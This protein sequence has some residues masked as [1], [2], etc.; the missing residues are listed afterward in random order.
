MHGVVYGKTVIK[1]R[2]IGSSGMIYIVRWLGDGKINFFLRFKFLKN[3][4]IIS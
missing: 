4:Y 2:R 3:L 1:L